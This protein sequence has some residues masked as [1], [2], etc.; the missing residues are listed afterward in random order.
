MKTIALRYGE[1]LAPENGTIGAHQELIDQLG[2][3]WYGKFGSP[4]SRS[5][6]QEV[7][8]NDD[9]RILLI[10]SGGQKRYWAHIDAIQ[11][12][13]PPLDAIPMYYRS[14]ATKIK[15]W[16]KIVKIQEAASNVLSRCTV[17]SSGKSLREASRSSMSPYFIINYDGEL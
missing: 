13:V 15:S 17:A 10:H 12:E 1:N 8:G 6:V 7:L 2:Y 9:P 4:V 14:I 5:V 11:R 3:V 16:I